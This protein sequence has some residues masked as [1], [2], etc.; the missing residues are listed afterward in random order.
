MSDSYCPKR[1]DHALIFVMLG[2]ESGAL[3]LQN[4]TIIWVRI[5]ADFQGFQNGGMACAFI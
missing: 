5:K 2:L 1:V 3:S 4:S